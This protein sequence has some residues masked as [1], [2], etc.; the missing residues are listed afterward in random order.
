MSASLIIF[1]RNLKKKLKKSRCGFCII[2]YIQH[3]HTYC[4]V[5]TSSLVPC[6]L[7]KETLPSCKKSFI[8]VKPSFF[9]ESF[10]NPLRQ[11]KSICCINFHNFLLWSPPYAFFGTWKKPCYMKLVLVGL[12]PG[13]TVLWSPT[14]ANSPTYTY[15]SQKTC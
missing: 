15:I 12:R 13:G 3:F 7:L 2:L 5:I 11:L 9:L 14:N 10:D 1:V 4:V 6:N 8:L